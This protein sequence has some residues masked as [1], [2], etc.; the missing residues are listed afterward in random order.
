[1]LETLVVKPNIHWKLIDDT[2][3]VLDEVTR[4]YF[5][6]DRED[7]QIWCQYLSR[8]SDAIDNAS[9]PSSSLPAI[10]NAA[11]DRKWL[12]NPKNVSSG[13]GKL[14]HDYGAWRNFY[15]IHA[16]ACLY[17]VANNLKLYGFRK[18]YDAARGIHCSTSA[19]I[20]LPTASKA[21][22]VAERFITT[23]KASE[24]CLGRSLALY[25]FLTRCG[26]TVKHHIG[27]QRHPFLAHAWVENNGIPILDTIEK[28]DCYTSI[29]SL[30]SSCGNT[31]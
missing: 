8:T 11:I 16:A 6:F 5:A 21:F 2:V 10:I 24:D 19:T 3:V 17:K 27:V 1:M 20:D 4:R 13:S 15:P 14:R 9:T 7:S 31:E 22:L 30:I 28:I 26:F 29:A 12:V 25:S 23:K 18:S